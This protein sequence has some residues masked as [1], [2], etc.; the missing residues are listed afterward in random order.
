MSTES[1]VA[2][3][4]IHDAESA[5]EESAAILKDIAQKYGFTPALYGIF[6]GS[7]AVL[8]TYL[9]IA[10]HFAATSLSP[11]EQNALLLA[12][13]VENK[14][15]FCRAAHTWTS[16]GAKVGD[17]DIAA[18][19]KGEDPSDAKLAAIARFA[20]HL[21]RERG[22]ASADEVDAFIGAG[23]ERHQVLEVV[24]GVTM[25]TLSNYTNHLGDT[26]INGPLKEF[27]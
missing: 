18:L 4:R 14:C 25:K 16:K 10:E 27:A 7:P 3:L 12:I 1:G 11:Q 2:K 15:D 17:T 21:V 24:L 26:P 22:F 19:R 8:K 5:P 20:R 6:A 9:Q 23:F 13:S